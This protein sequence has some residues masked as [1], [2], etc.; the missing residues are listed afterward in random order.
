MNALVS[1]ERW[2]EGCCAET[3][4]T[5]GIRTAQAGKDEIAA[6]GQTLPMGISCLVKYRQHP[7]LFEQ[8]C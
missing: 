4:T 6:I 5:L 8:E 3:Q 7:L 2:T 1:N